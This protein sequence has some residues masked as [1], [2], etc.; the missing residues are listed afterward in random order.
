MHYLL[1][2]LFFCGS[3]AAYEPVRVYVDAVA[4]LMHPG[5]IAMFKRARE[6]GDLL[7][8]GIHSDAVVAGYK[9]QPIMT[10][11][12]RIA[13][14][15]ACRYVD[16][17]IPDAPLHPSADYFRSHHIDLVIH[18]DDLSEE[19]QRK[20][21]GE[22]I[23]LGIFKTIPYTEGISTTDLIHRVLTLYGQR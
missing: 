21:Y 12:E 15:Q 23:R 13:V 19:N 4:D 5:H 20:W 2:S 1:L 6:Q 18:G 11:E 22:A 17:V 10:M 8:V 7:V 9:R 16:E 14:V 3:L